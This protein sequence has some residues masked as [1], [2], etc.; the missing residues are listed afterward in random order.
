LAISNDILEKNDKLN[1]TEI[2][3]FRK[4]AYYTHAVLSRINGLEDVA[5]W[6][7][8]HHERQ[9]GNGYFFRIKGREFSKLS[10]IMAVS[11]ILSA[12]TED[13]PYRPGMKRM[14]TT[15]MLADMARNGEIDVNI[16]SQAIEN[17][18][19]INNARAIAQREAK[20][21]Y[22]SLGPM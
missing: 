12:L 9:D 19:R 16:A 10:R 6:A 8:F 18:M 17:F 22:T 14:E 21:E 11:D 20:N 13:R 7:A 2:N 5:A 1:D 3:S 4:H 15:I